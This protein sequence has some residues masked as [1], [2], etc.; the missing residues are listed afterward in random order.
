MVRCGIGEEASWVTLTALALVKPKRVD[1]KPRFSSI[2]LSA[3]TMMYE[4]LL[5]GNGAVEP[6]S[7][8]PTVFRVSGSLT[9]H[10]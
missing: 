8:A 4:Q 1:V 2:P 6:F 3:E 7:P 5:D 10:S 9:P